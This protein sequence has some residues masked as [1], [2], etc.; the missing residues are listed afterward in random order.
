MTKWEYLTVHTKSKLTT[1]LLWVFNPYK[2]S[3]MSG[4]NGKQTDEA[5]TDLGND[6]WELVSSFNHGKFPPSFAFKRPLG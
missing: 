3:R 6:G 4:I 5:F 1:V 2:D